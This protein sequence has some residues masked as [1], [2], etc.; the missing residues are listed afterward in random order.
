[1]TD[2]I[3]RRTFLAGALT[4][5]ATPA[6]SLPDGVSNRI[7]VT[8]HRG[9]VAGYLVPFFSDLGYDIIGID[10]KDGDEFDLG[11]MHYTWRERIHR[12]DT[13]I[14]L[15]ADG[16]PDASEASVRHNNIRATANLIQVATNIGARDIIFASSTSVSLGRYHHP[17]ISTLLP[18]GWYGLS[19][20][21]G[22]QFPREYLDTGKWPTTFTTIRLGWITDKGYVPPKSD[23]P[24]EEWRRGIWVS[25]NHLCKCFR[26]TVERKGVRSP[27][28]FM[29]CIGPA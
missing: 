19:K 7:V 16:N 23:D 18:T 28:E 13:I 29:E 25:E 8:G 2:L 21:F 17:T 22:E 24:V 15:A 27:Y 20:W 4:A 14:H 5:A 1:M 11:D 10:K 6:A 26:D 3:K 9:R 12:G